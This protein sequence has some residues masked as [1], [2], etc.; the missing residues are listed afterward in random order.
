MSNSTKGGRG[1]RAPYETIM[2]RTPKPIKAVIEERIAK[3]R[4]LV[5]NYE[6]PEDPELLAVV[7][8][9][10]NSNELQQLRDEVKS[11]E[12]KLKLARKKTKEFEEQLAE[13]EKDINHL[14]NG[15]A[16][17]ILT[18]KIRALELENYQLKN[19][20]TTVDEKNIISNAIT[21]YIKIQTE[22]YGKNGAQKGEFNMNTRKWDAFKDF[23]S[24]FFNK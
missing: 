20:V 3:Y 6:N 14:R 21:K 5:D 7:S 23:M 17:A 15:G 4:E 18:N 1:K 10:N 8:S 2:C 13:A 22:N 19:S 24:Q 12:I 11:L 16:V 9:S